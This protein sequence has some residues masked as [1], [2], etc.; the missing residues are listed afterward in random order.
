MGV[1]LI[2]EHGTFFVGVK[3]APYAGYQAPGEVVAIHSRHPRYA[4]MAR[5]KDP[6]T[7]EKIYNKPYLAV[8]WGD[9][10]ETFLMPVEEVKL[11]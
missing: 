3:V 4:E 2:S 10:T 9:E 1:A 8:K 5:I 6:D 7:L 11:T